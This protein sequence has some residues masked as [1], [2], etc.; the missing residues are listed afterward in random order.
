MEYHHLRNATGVLGLGA[1]RLLIDPMLSAPGALPGFKLFGGGRRR[2]PLV[3]LPPAADAALADVTAVLVTH[4]HPDHLDGP[5]LS[6][7][8]ARGLPVWVSP[9][10]V[11]NLRRKGLDAHALADG[12]LGMT[13]EVVAVRHGH[14]PIGWL[15]G[16]VAGVYLAH[17]DEPSV[18]LTSDAVLDEAL[19]RT[20]DRLRPDVIVAPAGAA[21]FGLGR[22]ILFSSEE[23]V[24][25]ARR[26]PGRVI[27]NHLE[28]IDHCP[29]SRATL[30][31]RLA[32]EGLGERASV[33][34]DG[35]LLRLARPPESTVAAVRA[36]AGGPG[37]QKRV[38][39]L[40]TGT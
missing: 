25:L 13:L 5:G 17:P 35:D 31:S 39:A 20:I 15:M 7:I 14:G 4:E 32:A 28:A 9:V 8:R 36:F 30:R 24:A 38:T 27:F 2:N 19:L 1:H 16:P 22:D 33:P 12:A 6:W 29:M 37:L 26:A 18:L 11:D 21:N 10:D 3:P 23:L 34:N 40:F